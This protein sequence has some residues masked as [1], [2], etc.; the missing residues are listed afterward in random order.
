M[1]RSTAAPANPE[2]KLDFG[3]IL[4]VFVIVL[5]DLLGISIIIPL[6]SLYAASFGANALMIGLLSA[7]YPIMQFIFAPILGRLSDRFGRKPILVVS[8]IGSLIGFLVMG[9]AGSLPVLFLARIIDGISGGNISAAQAVIT[10][11]T[12]ERN[13]TQALGL[14]GAAFGLGFTIGPVIAYAVLAVTGGNY[15]AVAFV[16]AAFSFFSILLTTFW[17]KESHPKEKRGTDHKP[18][19]SLD[20]ITHAL[21]KPQIG[22]LLTL[23]F[24]AQFVFGGLEYLLSLF[25]LN[26]LGMDASG[27]ALLF[28]FIGVITIIVLGGMIGRWSKTYGDRKVILAGLIALGLGMILIAV[29]PAQPPPGYNR[30]DTIARL[31]SN[32]GSAASAVEQAKLSV[33]LPPDT[34][35]GYLGVLWIFA[36]MI[37]A[38]VGGGILS[39]TINSAITKRSNPQE[40]GGMLGISA[41]MSSA[42]NAIT[43][44]VGGAMFQFFGSTVAFLVGGILLLALFFFTQR[45]I[46]P[47]PQP[48]TA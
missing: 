4:P 7:A 8:Q 3:R 36:A 16:A 22:A 23:M 30:A 48:A 11:S 32:A 18:L 1:K 38:A 5:I 25:T 33:D 47:P 21:R 31:Q 44:I 19:V 14:I 41:S 42:A 24:M 15:H 12:N 6:V 46:Q 40:V 35:T 45:A 37:P 20:A 10:D 34:N 29:T 28:V 39:P 43:P 2:D 9:L 26:R 27:N 13:R 17:L